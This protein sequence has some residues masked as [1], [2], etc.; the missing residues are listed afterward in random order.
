MTSPIL[1]SI[2]APVT[3][4]PAA[5]ADALLEYT[6][7]KAPALRAA[8]DADPDEPLIALF[9]EGTPFGE[10][11]ENTLKLAAMIK[12]DETLVDRVKARKAAASGVT[13]APGCLVV[14]VRDDNDHRYTLDQ[15]V[16]VHRLSSTGNPFGVTASG[17]APE[18]YLGRKP[19]ALR[20]PTAE[21]ARGFV[22]AL[23]AAAPGRL[24]AALAEATKD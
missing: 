17:E 4:D 15:P 20:L 18:R 5:V 14:P 19:G 6:A 10:Y 2:F 12:K 13:L 23:A 16:L 7:R 24:V 11:W 22:A 9:A 8:A 1:A 3:S 21:E